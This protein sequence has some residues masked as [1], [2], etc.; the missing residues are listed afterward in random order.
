M[1]QLSLRRPADPNPVSWTRPEQTRIRPELADALVNQVFAA[2][3]QLAALRAELGRRPP[4][5]RVDA[6]A[7][8]LDLLVRDIRLAVVEGDS[9]GANPS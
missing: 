9:T 5:A 8:I 3:L 6:L 7:D 2:G 1:D 4:S